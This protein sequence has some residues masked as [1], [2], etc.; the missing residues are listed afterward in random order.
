MDLGVMIR[1]AAVWTAVAEAL[2]W[3]EAMEKAGNGKR[4]V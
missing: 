3:T 4:D 1:V 2:C